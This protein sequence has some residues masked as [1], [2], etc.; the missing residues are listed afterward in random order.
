MDC[1]GRGRCDY[2]VGTCSCFR[3]FFG[4]RCEQQSTLV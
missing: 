4:E 3:G 2:T 1:S